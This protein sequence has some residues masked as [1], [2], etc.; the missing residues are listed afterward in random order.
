M[1]G[2]ERHII[3]Y[4][5]LDALRCD[6][7]IVQAR[8]QFRALP[9]DGGEV[10]GWREQ[11]FCNRRAPRGD[12]G[13]SVFILGQ[14]E[15]I[16]TGNPATLGVLNCMLPVKANAQIP[17]QGLGIPPNLAPRI[18]EPGVF[19]GFGR[20]WRQVPFNASRRVNGVAGFRKSAI[21]STTQLFGVLSTQSALSMGLI[22]AW[23]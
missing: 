11:L 14:R 12:H 22:L 15:G 5:L 3:G 4:G 6:G 13:S 16:A 18:P 2:E 20:R 17:R 19:P 8:R 23:G 7:H 1:S 21:C 9:C 10:G